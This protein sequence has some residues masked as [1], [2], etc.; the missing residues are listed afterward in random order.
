MRFTQKRFPILKNIEQRPLATSIGFKRR[1]T[2]LARSNPKAPIFSAFKKFILDFPVNDN[3]YYIASTIYKAL[4]E[5][6]KLQKKLLDLLGAIK[7]ESGILLL[8]T[9]PNGQLFTYGCYQIE[10]E[11]GNYRFKIGMGHKEGI[12]VFL[13]G[14]TSEVVTSILTT[15]PIFPAE[16]THDIITAIHNIILLIV[17]FKQYA[18]IETKIL[19]NEKGKSKKIVLDGEKYLND[20]RLP[21]QVIDSTWFTDII[22]KEGFWVRGHFGLRACGP[23]R[24]ERK[25]TWIEA[26]EKNGYNRKAKRLME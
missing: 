15:N 4:N 25:L 14:N 7:S 26:Y 11:D 16:D 2:L 10:N 5:D 1:I 3:V 8:P 12:D 22:R 13:V 24:K 9:Q 17:L 18:P 19:K 6:E 21:I 20:T 23:G